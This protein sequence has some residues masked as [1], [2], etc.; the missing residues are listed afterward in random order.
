[1]ILIVFD[2][3]FDKV[4]EFDPGIRYVFSVKPV[5]TDKADVNFLMYL[6]DGIVNRRSSRVCL[7]KLDDVFPHKKQMNNRS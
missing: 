5:S 6:V 1:M 7:Y 4:K 3:A 2:G